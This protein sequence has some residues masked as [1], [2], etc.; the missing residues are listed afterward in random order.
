[1]PRS[2]R[3]PTLIIPITPG[4]TTIHSA[5][6]HASGRESRRRYETKKSGVRCLR[7]NPTLFTITVSFYSLTS[8]IA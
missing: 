4:L 7:S 2:G 8:H 3:V 6:R 1:M 5:R